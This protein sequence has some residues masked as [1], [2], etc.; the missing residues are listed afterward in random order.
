MEFV[1]RRTFFRLLYVII[2][3][4]I[5]KT[6]GIGKKNRKELKELSKTP[7]SARTVGY[8]GDISSDLVFCHCPLNFGEALFSFAM[9][10]R[11]HPPSCSLSRAWFFHDSRRLALTRRLGFRLL[12]VIVFLLRSSHLEKRPLRQN[13][14]EFVSTTIADENRS[15]NYG[16]FFSAKCAPINSLYHR[17]WVMSRI[18]SEKRWKKRKNFPLSPFRLIFSLDFVLVYRRI[19]RKTKQ[20]R[21]K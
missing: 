8:W 12:S 19:R 17:K 13:L 11:Y 5:G 2:E 6:R 15:Y 9:T 16:R 4:K 21:K 1:T 18:I 20:R 10:F 7:T 3:H 14:P